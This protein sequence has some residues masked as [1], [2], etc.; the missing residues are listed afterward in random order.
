MDFNAAVIGHP[1]EHSLSPAIHNAIYEA[2][3]IP[4]RYGLRDCPTDEDV[5]AA[6]VEGKQATMFAQE[7]QEWFAGYNVTTPY[8][9]LAF[10]LADEADPTAAVI[11]AA[12]VL[13]F[14]EV[15]DESACRPVIT[16]ASTDGE[17][18]CRALERAGAPVEGAKMLVLGTGGAALSIAVSALVRGASWVAI[19]SRDAVRASYTVADLVERFDKLFEGGES[20]AWGFGDDVRMLEG[21]SEALGVLEVTGYEG[22]EAHASSYDI[23]VNAT[24]LGMKAG[25]PSPLPAG[26][27]RGDHTVM[28]CVYG[29]GETAFRTAAAEAGARVLDGLPMLVEQALLT[30]EIWCGS[31]GYDY[32]ANDPALYDV[33]RAAGIDA[34]C[35]QGDA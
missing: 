33:L 6:I 31:I 22:I 2:K 25:D 18:A 12:N 28:D 35:G 7:P 11:R 32:S 34:P 20:V 10:E 23:I 29:H 17:G 15:C 5:R 27:F 16:C 24:P 9:S 19:A 1:V 3:G 4:W 26:F 30:I 8:K 14:A 13:Q 21:G